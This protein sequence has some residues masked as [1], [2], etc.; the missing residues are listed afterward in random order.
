MRAF[1]AWAVI[2]WHLSDPLGY[3]MPVFSSGAFAVDIFMNISGFLMMYHYVAR[4]PVEPWESPRTWGRFLVRRF[5]RIAPLYYV[6]LL[7]VFFLNLAPPP[8]PGSASSSVSVMTGGDPPSR[9]DLKFLLLHASF[10]FGLFPTYSGDNIMPD[11]SLSLEMQFYACFPFLALLAN[12]IGTAA[13]FFVCCLIGA[14]ANGLISYYPGSDPGLLGTFRQPSVLPLKLHIFAVGIVAAK[15]YY[16]GFRELRSLW[17]LPAFVLFA[18]TCKY[19]YT[20]LLGSLYWLL[21]LAALAPVTAR[22]VRSTFSTLNRW[23]ET[24]GWFRWPADLS[25]SGFLMHGI[26]FVFIFGWQSGHG[27]GRHVSTGGFILI[28]TAILLLVSAI[29][30]VLFHSIEKPGIRLGKRLLGRTLK[31]RV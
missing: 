13:F 31:P 22:W 17:Y 1:A 30:L 10:L 3:K 4:R 9:F 26:V 12:R 19:N 16:D 24:L 11:W 2:A 14:I 27:V 15:V 18:L 28:Y 20:R 8:D 6:L 29:G 21:F 25:Y 5:F 7:V 23:C